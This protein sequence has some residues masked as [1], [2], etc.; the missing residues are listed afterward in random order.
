MTTVKP[1]LTDR[2]PEA[3]LNLWFGELR[4]PA[5]ASQ[6]NWQNAMKRWRVGPFGRALLDEAF[7]QAQRDWCEQ[8][9]REGLEFFF[10]DHSWSTPEGVLAKLIVL[11]Q[12]PRTVY[13][14]TALAYEHDEFT[15]TLAWQTCDMG[16]DTKHFNVIERS[17]IYMPLAHAEDLTLQEMAIKKCVEWGT[18]LMTAVPRDRRR[19]NQFVSWSCL[20]GAI[21]H[22]ETLLLFDRFPHRNAVLLRPH[23]GGEVRYLKS[24]QRPPWSFTQPPEPDYFAMLGTLYREGH[25]KADDQVSREAVETLLSMAGLS[26]SEQAPMMSIFAIAGKDRVPYTM[27]YRHLLLPEH[28]TARAQVQ[29]MP[30]VEEL[31]TAVKQLILKDGRQRWPPSNARQSVRPAIDVAALASLVRNDARTRRPIRRDTLTASPPLRLEV[32]NADAEFE[33]VADQVGGFAEQHGFL[34]DDRFQVQIC[35]EELL[36]YVMKEGSASDRPRVVELELLIRDGS[37]QLEVRTAHEGP[38][39]EC[40][41]VTFQ[42]SPDTIDEE[43]VLS[44]LGLHLVHTYADQLRQRYENGRNIFVMTKQL[45]Q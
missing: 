3:A 40:W 45:G 35:V 42:P 13:R 17:W 6:R 33:R 28:A 31:A 18:D 12:F 37:D 22:S 15:G 29:C 21:E 9:H 2:T 10:R 16:W 38:E 41:D 7:V 43:T 27:L 39:L 5:D 30:V 32:R 4:T 20:K 23:R 11:D 14:G 24:V 8:I 1:Q 36:L 25:I 26:H 44:G 34:H 19:I